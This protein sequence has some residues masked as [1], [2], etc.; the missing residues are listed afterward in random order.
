MTK[1]FAV[2]SVGH[3]MPG[4]EIEGLDAD[5][6][7]ALLDCGAIKE[8][9]PVAEAHDAPDPKLL[10]LEKQVAELKA[11]NEKLS[12]EKTESEKQVAELKDEVTALKKAVADAEKKAKAEAK[13]EK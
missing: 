1:Y 5:R 2:G 7:Q 13:T 11:G 8:A 12:A 6:I 3:F 9:D 10:E 4:D